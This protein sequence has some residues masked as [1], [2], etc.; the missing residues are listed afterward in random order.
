MTDQTGPAKLRMSYSPKR[1]FYPAKA[2]ADDTMS[3][4]S[5]ADPS[6][7]EFY[8]VGIGPANSTVAIVQPVLCLIRINYKC[9]WYAPKPITRS[10]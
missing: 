4:S 1:T 7:S 9:I 2:A 6:E 3:G 5:T 10:D 8:Q